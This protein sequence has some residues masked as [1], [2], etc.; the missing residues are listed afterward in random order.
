MSID[1]KPLNDRVLVE[2]VLADE[3]TEAG[4]FLPE[5]AR[6][7]P[8]RARVVAVGDGGYINGHFRPTQLKVGDTV[9][10]G[11]FAGSQIKIDG[12]DYVIVLED[13]VFGTVKA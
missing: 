10:M 2:M 12:R 9:L 1:F 4:L 6:E 8:T 7:K 3:K 13:D 11:K 5:Q